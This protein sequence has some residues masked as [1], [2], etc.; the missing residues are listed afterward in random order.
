MGLKLYK[1]KRNFKNT[2]EPEG[3]VK[4]SNKK[5][6]F[7][8]QRH[9]ASRL[10]YDFRLELDGVMKSW[11]VPKGPS[12]NPKDKRLAVMVEDHPM[13]YN[14]FHG[15]IPKG[16]YGAGTVDIWD[17]GTYTVDPLHAKTK[18]ATAE[19]RKM[20]EKG[21][22]KIVMKGK[23][24]NGSFAL[25]R[26]RDEKNWLLIKHR[27]EYAVDDYDS[28]EIRAIKP[29][30]AD[31]TWQSNR[32]NSKQKSAQ[33]AQRVSAKSHKLTHYIKPMLATPSDVPFNDEDWIF[34]IKWDGYRAV[35]EKKG[36]NIKF[37]S[38]N[39]LSFNE[40]YPELIPELMKIKKDCVLD[41]EIVVLNEAGRP[42]FQKL[43][44]FDENRSLPILYYVFD[45]LS[46]DGKDLTDLSLIERKKYAL[47]AIPKSNAIIYSDHIER[48]GEKFFNEIIKLDGLEGMMA[49]RAESTYEEGRRSRSW[50]KIKLVNTQEAIIAGYTAP[51]ESRKYF[52]ALILGVYDKKKLRYIG[53]SGTGFSDK[54]LK[55]LHA[56][57]QPLVTDESPFDEKVPVNAAVTWVEPELVC[58]VKFSELT[59]EGIMRHPVFMGLRIDK[60]PEEVDHVDEP[61]KTKI[62]SDK[63]TTKKAAAKKTVPKKEPATKSSGKSSSKKSTDI[64]TSKENER[65][66]TVD[67]HDLKL[68]NQNKIFWPEEKYTK[69]DVINYYNK[70]SDYILPYLIDR[71]QSLKRNPG[72]IED[73]GFY[74]KDAGHKAPDW[75]KSEE[76][77]SES[78]NKTIDYIIC[79]NKAT[80]IYLANLGCI[81]LNPWNS[82]IKKPD[83]PDYLIMD[84]DPS[85]KNTFNQ[86]IDVALV[87]KEILDKAGCTSYC[88][89]SGA[90]GMHIYIPLQGAYTY[91]QARPFSEIIAHLTNEQLPDFTT[92]ERPLNQRKG[93]IYIDFLQNRRGQTLSSVY[94]IRPV[95]GASV[96]TPLKWKEVK[97]G[98]SPLDFTIKTALK[99]FDK[100]GD[101]FAN[102]LTDKNDLRKCI[103]RL[104]S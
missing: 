38:R 49:K 16:N 20:L 98:L 90:T 103:D 3:K 15:V 82:R 61:V 95:P 10:H 2:P 48:D 77:Y 54:M 88:K 63:K 50:L 101:L 91:D 81:E 57:L 70:V 93:R 102:V 69:G 52:G 76:V 83:N 67:G 92:V 40:L 5:L 64:G 60:E 4:A 17:E 14:K 75:V 66:V 85:E 6:G 71:P 39:G 45:C 68:T 89:T 37:Y 99:R 79:N 56:K 19:L 12:L 46:Y 26:L 42:S 87:I 28:E 34:E 1:K 100:V 11:A 24:L 25:V 59:D 7:V 22:L 96:S 35:T 32:P 73:K 51:R 13:E 9:D 27:D 72:G 55:E 44:Q 29:H 36:K 74:H 23:H 33:A 8:I 86:V 62:K 21:Q 53:H 30:N 18:N 31:K 41:G 43:Q 65:I 84:I 58:N 80:L 78:G 97:H 47:K 94:S 104:E